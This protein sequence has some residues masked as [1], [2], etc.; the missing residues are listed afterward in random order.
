MCCLRGSCRRPRVKIRRAVRRRYLREIACKRHF[1]W[2]FSFPFFGRPAN[3][4]FTAWASFG[5]FLAFMF[6]L[7][8]CS[9]YAVVM[10][11]VFNLYVMQQWRISIVSSKLTILPSLTDNVKKRTI[12]TVCDSFYIE[13]RHIKVSILYPARSDC[14]SKV[15]VSFG[16]LRARLVVVF[17]L[18]F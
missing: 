10:W 15:F 2:L 9:F 6:S 12:H 4:I 1:R 3:N 16:I 5:V 17:I 7:F 8:R 14:K 11:V 13:I 18:P